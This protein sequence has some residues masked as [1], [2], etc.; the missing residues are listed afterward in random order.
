MFK[1]INAFKKFLGYETSPCLNKCSSPHNDI[2]EKENNLGYPQVVI[3]SITSQSTEEYKMAEAA[4]ELL[5][6]V[7]KT[8]V[9]KNR[10]ISTPMTETNNLNNEAIYAL[11]SKRFYKI[12]VEFFTGTFRQNYIYH[13][14]GYDVGNGV[15]YCN[16]FFVKDPE[17]LSSLLMHELM[18]KLGFKH[19]KIKST[20][21]PYQMNKIIE[22]CFNFLGIKKSPD[23]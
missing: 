23:L 20:S 6:R 18:H 16:R 14:V 4:I 15:T 17:T 11:L 10:L 21:V 12:N 22:Y 8:E 2:T 9:F 19:N 7:L 3:G 5:N 13:T 1:F